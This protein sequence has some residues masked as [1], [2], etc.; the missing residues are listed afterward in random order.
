ML[1]RVCVHT[2]SLTAYKKALALHRARRKESEDARAEWQRAAQERRD[3]AA[4]DGGGGGGGG[5]FG[6]DDD[7]EEG[8]DDTGPSLHVIPA[9]LLN[10]VGV[11]CYRAGEMSEAAA[12]F[13][14]AM[15]VRLVCTGV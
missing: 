12:L 15:Q 4:E 2:G 7:P 8:E 9:I 13:E 14:E 11:L 10:N 3:R 6:D 5:L 1:S